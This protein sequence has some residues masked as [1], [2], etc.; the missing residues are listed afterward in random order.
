MKELSL[1]LIASCL[2]TLSSLAGTQMIYSTSGGEPVEMQGWVASYEG[3]LACRQANINYE[4]QSY[5]HRNKVL[6]SA[7][8]ANELDLRLAMLRHGLYTVTGQWQQGQTC[9]CFEVASVRND[10]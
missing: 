5:D 2:T 7:T 8:G 6:L 1:V 9:P 4:L 10:F 3:D